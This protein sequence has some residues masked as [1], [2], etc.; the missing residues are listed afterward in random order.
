MLPELMLLALMHL[1]GHAIG[2]QP[3]WGCECDHNTLHFYSD[4]APFS[5]SMPITKNTQWIAHTHPQDGDPYP[6]PNDIAIAKR[7]HIPDMVVSIHHVY[8][9]H[10]DGSVTD[11]TPVP[12]KKAKKKHHA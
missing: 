1:Q 12:P 2:N 11:E 5:V 10:A 4:N 6:S 7:T 9:V 3:E 8:L